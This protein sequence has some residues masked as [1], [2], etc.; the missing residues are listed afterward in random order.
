VGI[1]GI[2]PFYTKHIYK[3]RPIGAIPSGMTLGQ[4]AA[5]DPEGHQD[6][7]SWEK[8]PPP[9]M[10]SPKV[11]RCGKRHGQAIHKEGG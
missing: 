10:Q 8:I 4:N 5:F 6:Q 3:K 1:T 2:T 7:T 11:L 9:H